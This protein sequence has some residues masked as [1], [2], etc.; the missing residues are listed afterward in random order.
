MRLCLITLTS[1]PGRSGVEY[2]LV[3]I[4]PLSADRFHIPC[5]A[6]DDLQ[7]YGAALSLTYPNLC[8]ADQTHITVMEQGTGFVQQSVPD[9]SFDRSK[10]GVHNLGA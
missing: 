10:T 2:V 3:L 6:I 4:L 7:L 9:T 1:D 5:Q 8:R